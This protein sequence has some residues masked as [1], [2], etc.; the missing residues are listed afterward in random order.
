[1]E[2]NLSTNSTSSYGEETTA[3]MTETTTLLKNATEQIALKRLQRG[4]VEITEEYEK[5]I[6]DGAKALIR[7]ATQAEVA[8]AKYVFFFNNSKILIFFFKEIQQKIQT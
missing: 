6:K 8:L 5:A 4:Y 1:M 7:A 3:L 2:L